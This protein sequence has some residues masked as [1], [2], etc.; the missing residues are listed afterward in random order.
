MNY[1]INKIEYYLPE[2]IIDNVFLESE[3]GIEKGFLE[4]KIGIKFRHV[5]EKNESVSDMSFK[6]ARKLIDV[7]NI[8][9]ES[10]DLLLVCTQ[11]PDYKLPTT[12]CIV[13]DKLKLKTS[14]IAFDVNLG[15]SGFVYSVIIAGNFIK[16]NLI[17]NALIIMADQYSKIINYKDRNTAPLFGDAASA[18]LISESNEKNGVIDVDFGTDGSGAE[19]LIAYNSGVVRDNDKSS[20]LYMN[21][22]EVLKFSITSV[23]ESIAKIL[24]RNKLTPK[25]VKYFVLHQANKYLLQEISKALGVADEQMVIDLERYGNTVSSTIPIALKNLV[26]KNCLHKGDLIILSGFGVGFSWGTILYEY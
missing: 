5:A 4:N 24:E 13:Q 23:P 12:A 8:D 22:R 16:S 3:C 25:D 14:C 1:F 20:F 2:K 17:K 26:D 21:G 18:I 7:N 6:A 15:C 11:N 10:I 19:N 9:A